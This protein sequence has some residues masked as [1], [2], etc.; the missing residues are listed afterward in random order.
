MGLRVVLDRI[1]LMS[2]VVSLTNW[3]EYGVV[4]FWW[5]I[6]FVLSKGRIVLKISLF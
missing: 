5:Y 3:W 4:W 6:S 1:D 2:F